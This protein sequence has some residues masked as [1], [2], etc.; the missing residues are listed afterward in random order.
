MRLTFLLPITSVI[1]SH[2]FLKCQLRLSFNFS[3]VVDI[4][5]MPFILPGPSLS[6]SSHHRL[7]KGGVVNE[8]F[9]LCLHPP[10]TKLNS[11]QL[12]SAHQRLVVGSW[13]SFA[14]HFGPVVFEPRLF[15]RAAIR[16]FAHEVR[17]VFFENIISAV[18]L[19][20][21]DVNN[22]DDSVTEIASG[23]LENVFLVAVVGEVVSFD[24]KREL[25]D[26]RAGVAGFRVGISVP[27]LLLDGK[28]TL[29][30]QT[31]DPARQMTANVVDLSR[32][33]PTFAPRSILIRLIY[34]NFDARSVAFAFVS[35]FFLRKGGTKEKFEMKKK[36]LK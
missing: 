1:I 22:V 34:D 8:L 17:W 12:V 30:Q 24:F 7:P 29:G 23:Q 35:A 11:T 33:L 25:L 9:E 18:E 36:D 14:F 27:S 3:D 13:L 16:F 6:V 5:A 26:K 4:Q 32:V 31:F 10:V 19:I 20:L 21:D 15:K 28:R 2:L